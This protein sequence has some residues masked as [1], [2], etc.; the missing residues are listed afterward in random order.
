M[1]Q[2]NNLTQGHNPTQ[3]QRAGRDAALDV[4]CSPAVTALI[5]LN[6]HQFYTVCVSVCLFVSL[7]LCVRVCSEGDDAHTRP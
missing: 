5:S 1:Q 2:G 3:G 6:R 4:M 7:S